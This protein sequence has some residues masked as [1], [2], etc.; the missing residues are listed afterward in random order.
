VD[1]N[2]EET[3]S[4]ELDQLEGL[5]RA[6][7]WLVLPVAAA[8]AL[9]ALPALPAAAEA[10]TVLLEAG[11]FAAVA[12]SLGHVRGVA[13]GEGQGVLVDDLADGL[14][15]GHVVAAVLAALAEAGLGGRRGTSS[16]IR[17]LEKQAQ[18]ILR[19]SLFEQL[20]PVYFPLR[21]DPGSPTTSEAAVGSRP[22]C[23]LEPL[24]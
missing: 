22:S 13:A 9:A 1:W 2:A 24:G 18:Y 17:P 15:A 3:G 20:H 21:E 8:V 10:L 4:L 16:H 5:V 11:R 19:H 14:R 7:P 6:G 23:R 12:G